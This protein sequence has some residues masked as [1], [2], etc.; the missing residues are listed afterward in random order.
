MDG[1]P[2][3]GRLAELAARVACPRRWEPWVRRLAAP[4]EARARSPG[5]GSPAPPEPA[6]DAGKP[7]TPAPGTGIFSCGMQNPT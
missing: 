2:G 5:A 4:P 7:E 3:H 6:G 1:R